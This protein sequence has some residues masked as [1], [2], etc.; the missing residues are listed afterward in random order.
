MGCGR[1]RLQ[2]L[3][4]RRGRTQPARQDGR[5]RA[6]PAAIHRRQRLQDRGRPHPVPEHRE[7]DGRPCG[8]LGGGL[9]DDAG[10]SWLPGRDARPEE[11]A[12]RA[13]GSLRT[14]PWNAETIGMASTKASMRRSSAARMPARS[15]P[16]HGRSSA[17]SRAPTSTWRTDAVCTASPARCCAGPTS[18]SSTRS[19]D[20]RPTSRSTPPVPAWMPISRTISPTAGI[21]E[22]SSC[23]STRAR[24]PSCARSSMPPAPRRRCSI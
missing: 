19:G 1:D 17:G 5:E 9:P 10:G 2:P 6:A 12:G 16:L 3:P 13:A 15:K 22:A 24:A 14:M 4:G 23:V 18:S 8:S 21:G 7:A 20:A 11:R